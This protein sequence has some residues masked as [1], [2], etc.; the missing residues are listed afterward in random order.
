ML[1]FESGVIL[2]GGVPP[3]VNIRGYLSYCSV[4][5]GGIIPVRWVYKSSIS[6]W[7]SDGKEED[8]IF[9]LS[10][11]DDTGGEDWLSKRAWG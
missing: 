5:N 1:L 11:E 10:K 3:C 8:G 7:S 4:M 9:S 6:L 2:M